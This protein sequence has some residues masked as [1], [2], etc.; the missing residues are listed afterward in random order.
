MGV[1]GGEWQLYY[2]SGIKNSTARDYLCTTLK[3]YWLKSCVMLERVYFG[4]RMYWAFGVMGFS[5]FWNNC[6]Q[7]LAVNIVMI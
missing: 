7:I 2:V 6:P 5:P 1:H 3:C 4:P